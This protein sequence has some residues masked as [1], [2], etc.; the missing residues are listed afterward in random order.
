MTK[1]DGRKVGLLE[2]GDLYSNMT[3]DGIENSFPF[4]SLL[5]SPRSEGNNSNVNKVIIIMTGRLWCYGWILLFLLLIS[6]VFIEAYRND[7]EIRNQK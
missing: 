2:S 6:F 5:L 3:D 4:F 7:S 1:F